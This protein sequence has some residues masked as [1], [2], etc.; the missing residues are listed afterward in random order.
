MDAA[1]VLYMVN[2]CCLWF[3]TIVLRSGAQTLPSPG[4]MCA[5]PEAGSRSTA[6]TLLIYFYAIGI[7]CDS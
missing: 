1:V 2:I 7:F 5:S 3:V 6:S 4:A